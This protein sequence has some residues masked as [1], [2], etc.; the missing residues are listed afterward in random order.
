MAM[1]AGLCGLPEVVGLVVLRPAGLGPFDH[2][3]RAVHFFLVFVLW[4]GGAG[5]AGGA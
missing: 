5:L 4:C 3:R 1:M 2:V